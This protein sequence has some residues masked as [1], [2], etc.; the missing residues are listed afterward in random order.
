MQTIGAYSGLRVLAVLRSSIQ[1]PQP[2][3]PPYVLRLRSPTQLRAGPL[4]SLPRRESTAA[5]PIAR[6]NAHSPQQTA[7]IPLHPSSP[8]RTRVHAVVPRPSTATLPAPHSHRERTPP[9]RRSQPIATP[10]CTVHIRPPHHI[11]HRGAHHPSTDSACV[12]CP[13]YCPPDISFS[14][15]VTA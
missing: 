8:T 4:V 7:P 6:H 1:H 11:R 15:H 2:S 10:R 12:S 9:S 3:R 13:S 14:W 5:M